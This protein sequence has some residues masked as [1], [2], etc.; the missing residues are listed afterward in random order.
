MVGQRSDPEHI[1]RKAIQLCLERNRFRRIERILKVNRVSVANSAKSW[2]EIRGKSP[3]NEK[4]EVL[5][6]D[7]VCVNKKTSGS[8]P[9]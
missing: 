8:V 6:L 7:G 9:Q 5:V 2:R 1:R 3:K 4:I